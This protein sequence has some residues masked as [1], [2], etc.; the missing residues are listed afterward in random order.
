VLAIGNFRQSPNCL[1]ELAYADACDIPI[2]YGLDA[3]E[4]WRNER[5]HFNK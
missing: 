3:L 4:G 1:R 2:F 5:S